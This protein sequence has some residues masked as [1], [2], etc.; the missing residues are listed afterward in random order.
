[1]R[2]L[3]IVGARPQFIKLAPVSRAIAAHNQGGGM[4]IEDH[5]VHTGQHYDPS[6]SDVF[7]QELNIPKPK[8]ALGIGSGSHGAQTAEMLAAIARII[9]EAD[10][11]MVVVYG[12]TNSTLAGALAAAK[13]NVPLA[14]VEAGLRSFDRTMPEEVNRVVT[15]HVS[16][17][18]LAPTDTAMKNLA[19]ENLVGRASKSGDV[20]L[21]AVT[22]NRDLAVS[23]ST[24]LSQLNLDEGS[25][26]VLTLHRAAN[27][28]TA[29]L[30]V[31]LDAL[32]GVATQHIPLVFPMHPRTAAC[33]DAGAE[34]W[35]PAHEMSVIEPIGYLDMLALV[36]NAA[37]V[38]TDSGGLQKEAFLLGSPC[39][40]LRDDTEWT[41]TI[42]GG[43]NILVGADANR[44][45]AAV[46]DALSRGRNRPTTTS[47]T[48][49]FGDGKAAERIVSA[50][51]GYFG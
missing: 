51:S 33:I 36:D 48:R 14:H 16:D 24:I 34:I 43:G 35:Q 20:M 2:L 22:Y 42:D 15:D 50:I 32:N 17:L 19:N 4:P 28:D 31:L 30:G 39:I 11:D 21:D 13:L 6:L 5:I 1:M 7:F 23:R 25:Y 3:S 47:A 45:T 41:E 40:T 46:I 8:S 44:L 29:R 27:T 38:L 26:G 10:P 37:L 49:Y 12:D 9:E 18:L